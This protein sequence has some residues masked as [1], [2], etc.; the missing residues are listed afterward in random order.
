[1]HLQI[2]IVD[3][4]YLDQRS[5]AK[6]I[7]RIKITA[8][9]KRTWSSSLQWAKIKDILIYILMQRFWCCK[10]FSRWCLQD[11][12]QMRL[13]VAFWIVKQKPFSHAQEVRVATNFCLWRELLMMLCNFAS[14]V[15]IS[16][17]V[18]PSF[19]SVASKI[20]LVMG[21]KFWLVGGFKGHTL[22]TYAGLGL[23]TLFWSFFGCFQ[24]MM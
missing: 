4:E 12:V 6:E 15:Q 13:Q 8:V 9:S 21:L 10:R 3:S 18:K 24:G 14:I 22:V 16:N 5:D 7:Y 17:L 20:T 2:H 19:L 23:T 1:M 11:L